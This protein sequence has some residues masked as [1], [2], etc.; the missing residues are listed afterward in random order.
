MAWGVLEDTSL[1]EVPGTTLLDREPN[2]TQSLEDAS[3]KTKDGVVLVPQPS[4][5]PNDPFNWSAVKKNVIII[6]LALTSGVT[7]ALGPMIS[8]GLEVASQMY[9]VSLDQISSL[10]VGLFL[11]VTGSATFFTAASATVWGKRPVFVIS[12]FILL[13]TNVWGFF[14]TNFVSLVTMRIIQGLASAPLETLVTSTVSDIFFVHERGQKIAIW[15]VMIA[16]GVLLGQVISGY[17]IE[18]LGFLATFGVTAIIFVVLVPAIFFLVPETVYI[19]ADM[20]EDGEKDT[21]SIDKL[22]LNETPRSFTSQL[23]V[24]NGRLS[25]ESFWRLV[26]K[27]LPL[28]AFPAVVFSTLVYGSFMTWLVT[29]GVLSV[30]VFST[31]P[32][33]LNPAQIGLTNIPLLIVALIANPL[34]GYLADNVSRFMARRN[35]GI[36]E[37]EFRLTLMI[38]ATVVSTAGF[39]GFGISVSRGAPLAVPLFFMSLH[40]VSVGFASTAS[41]AYVID[42]HPQDANQAFVTINFFKA[43]FAFC[44]SLFVNRWYIASGPLMVFVT[45][46]IVNL[47]VSLLTVP[48]YIF[49]CSE[50]DS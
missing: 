36:Y 43:V 9:S 30:N 41:F 26:I 6:T 14:S 46:G 34:A 17:I 40:S 28:I 13:I 29:F 15:G 22:K 49:G 23:R 39:I 11:L 2:S 44:A 5:S 24:F 42:C 20:L 21:G 35:N 18:S 27:P 38:P 7:T 37:P 48:M 45:I 12:A 10:L 47:V 32:Y 1:A 33:N 4:G 31:A 16:S 19:K 3:L 8:P 50:S 25:N